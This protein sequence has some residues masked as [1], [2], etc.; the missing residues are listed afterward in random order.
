MT[1]LRLSVAG[2]DRNY[3][4]EMCGESGTVGKCWTLYGVAPDVV[5]SSL[6]VGPFGSFRYNQRKTR[7]ER[8]GR[9]YL[10]DTWSS[11]VSDGF[12]LRLTRIGGVR[13]S[14]EIFDGGK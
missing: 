8:Q 10:S 4:F 2:E 1:E 3:N 5:G 6:E 7:A 11:I 14:G 12:E 9:Q 13:V